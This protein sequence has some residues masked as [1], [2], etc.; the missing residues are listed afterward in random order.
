MQKALYLISYDIACAKRRRNVFNLLSSQ[1][2]AVQLSLFVLH[3]YLAKCQQLM[4][5][6]SETIVP[7]DDKLL[8][9]TLQ[10]NGYCYQQKTA[11][12]DIQLVHPHPLLNMLIN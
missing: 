1:A 2:F 8:C 9:I 7:E 4:A 10:S 3:D 11:D 6:L 12:P 5:Q